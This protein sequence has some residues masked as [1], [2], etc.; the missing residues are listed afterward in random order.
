LNNR[1][2][3]KN[4]TIHPGDRLSLFPRE[5]PIFVDWKDHRF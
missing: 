4:S 3:P 5:Y 2:V 1:A